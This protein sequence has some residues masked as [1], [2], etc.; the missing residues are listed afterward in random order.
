MKYKL[1]NNHLKYLQTYSIL[2]IATYKNLHGIF[3][4][5]NLL[6]FNQRILFP[7]RSSY[8]M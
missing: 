7:H 3:L 6:R 1:V 8:W 2:P 4:P 5:H